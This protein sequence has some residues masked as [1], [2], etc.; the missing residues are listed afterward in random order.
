M[1]LKLFWAFLWAF[2]APLIALFGPTRR[3]V[4]SLLVVLINY[5]FHVMHLL[6][7]VVLI[8]KPRKNFGRAFG[9]SRS[10]TKSHTLCGESV[11]MLCQQWWTFIGVRLYLVRVVLCVVKPFQVS[12][13]RWI[14]STKLHHRIPIPSLSYF[15]VFCSTERS[16]EQRFSWSWCGFC[17]IGIM[18]SSSVTLL[19]QWLSFAV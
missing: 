7:Q 2:D 15:P 5:W 17:G 12:S 4:C 14:D 18:Q 13:L 19:F 10:Q 16:L 9:S 3:L 11:T 8:L 1:K 6:V